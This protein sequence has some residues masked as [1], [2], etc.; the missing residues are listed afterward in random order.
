MINP[1]FVGEC[2]ACKKFV[3]IHNMNKKLQCGH[4]YCV[5]CVKSKKCP[6]CTKDDFSGCCLLMC[7]GAI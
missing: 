4:T 1:C 6:E 5:Y 7:L 2:M 3:D